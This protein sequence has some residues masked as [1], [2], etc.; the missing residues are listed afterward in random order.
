MNTHICEFINRI[1]RNSAH[2]HLRFIVNDPSIKDTHL[3]DGTASRPQLGNQ[4]SAYDYPTGG[5]LSA[6]LLDYLCLRVQNGPPSL[7]Y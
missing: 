4:H 6:I 3:V 2:I 5:K 1:Q 7:H